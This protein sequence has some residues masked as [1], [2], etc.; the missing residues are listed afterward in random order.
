MNAE[1]LRHQ[2]VQRIEP[3]GINTEPESA[4]LVLW[5]IHGASR[6]VIG[7]QIGDTL[8]ERT[9]GEEVE[10]LRIRAMREIVPNLPPDALRDSK[11]SAVGY[12]VY[13]GLP[14][15]HCQPT[16]Q[17]LAGTFRRPS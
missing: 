6:F 5:G 2:A 4:R 14:P 3:N 8:L 9:P 15:N 10:A 12:F 7:V 13:T 16:S 11:G 1:Q 17:H